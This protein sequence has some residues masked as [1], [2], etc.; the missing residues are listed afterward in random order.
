MAKKGQNSLE[1]NIIFVFSNQNYIKNEKN[2]TLICNL[3]YL[4]EINILIW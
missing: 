4:F 2:D 1:L 3:I